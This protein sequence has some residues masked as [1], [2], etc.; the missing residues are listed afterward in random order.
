MTEVGRVTATIDGDLSG[1]ESKLNEAR[2]KSVTAVSGI[3]SDIKSKFGSGISGISEGLSKSFSSGDFL[4]AGKRLGGDLVT[5][6]SGSFG[7]LG[8]AVGEVATALGPVGIAATAG[9]AALVGLGT[10]SIQAASSWETG[11]SQISKTTGIE[12]GTAE[13]A[14]LSSDLLEL[15]A[16]MPVAASE[17][18]SVATSAGSLGVASSEIA[19]FTS[20][21]LQMG[22][23]FDIP[24]EEAAVAI[25]KIKGQLKS[26]PEGAEGADEFAQHFGSAVDSVGNNLNAT[27]ADVLN[28]ATRV[29]GTLSGLGANAYEIAGWGGVLSSVFPSAER[30]AGAFDSAIT[31]LTTNTDAQT[32]ATDLLGISVEEF[33]QQISQDPT[34][35]LLSIGQA[36]ENLPADKVLEVSKAL[37]GSYGMDV[38]TKMIGHTEEWKQAIEETVAAGQKG[39]SIGDSFAAAANTASAQFQ[40]LKGS[41][42]AIFVDIGG[43]ILEAFTPVISGVADGLNDVREIGEN[44][45]EPFTTAISPATT[46]VGL[47]NDSIGGLVDL[48]LDTLVAGAKGI[49]TAFQTGKAFVS[50]FREELTEVV[51]ESETFQTISG[52]VEDFGEAISSVGDTASETFDGMVSWLSD[53]IPTA[54]SGA[55]DAIGTLFDQGMDTLGLGGTADSIKGAFSGLEGFLGDVYENASEKLG[56]GVEDAT[57]EGTEKGMESGS[58]AAEDTISN[59]TKS[60]VSEGFKKASPAIRSALEAGYSD[61]EA[62]AIINNSTSSGKAE[63][64]GLFGRG[65]GVR[66]AEENGIQYEIRYRATKR[67]TEVALYVDG[68]KMASGS[69]YSGQDEAIRD[70]FSQA[71]A[72]LG[73]ATSLTLQG[74]IGEAALVNIIS[75]FDYDLIAENFGQQFSDRL[76][77]EG[78]VIGRAGSE[79]AVAAFSSLLENMRSPMVENLG[80]VLEEIATLAAERPLA[81]SEYDL[82]GDQFKEKLLSQIVDA[83]EFVSTEMG[84]FGEPAAAALSGGIIDGTEASE[85][86]GLKPELEFLQEFFPEQFSDMGG[87]AALELIAALEAGDYEGAAAIISERLTI[88]PT[89]D[90]SLFNTAMTDVAGSVNLADILA[91][92]AE[93]KEK[94]MDVPEFMENTFQP[95]LETQIDFFKTQW[96]SGIAG[97]QKETEDFLSAMIYTSENMPYL[98]TADQVDILYKYSNG[99]ISAKSAIDALSDSADKAADSTKKLETGWDSLQETLQEDEGCECALSDFAK[100]QESQ[101]DLFQGAY[102]GRGGQEYLD[103]K[104]DYL[105]AIAETQEAMKAVGGAVL[106]E[107]YTQQIQDIKMKVSID[108]TDAEA[109]IEKVQEDIEEE[110]KMP[111]KVDDSAAKATI[112]GIDA[113]ASRPVTKLVYVQEVSVGGGGGYGGGYNPYSGVYSGYTGSFTPE[114]GGME[115][116]IYWLPTFASGDV[117][118]PEPTLAIVG[119]RP[120]G[121]W[122]GG[123]DQAVAR[124]GGKPSVNQSITVNYSPVING[125]DLSAAELSELLEEHDEKLMNKIGEKL[126]SSQYW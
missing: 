14:G 29:S 100:W 110:R 44:L 22:T 120:G 83:E 99:L 48:Q 109:S 52:Y 17:I 68:Q 63:Y 92:P 96:H 40:V 56:W 3:E 61:L 111:L 46:A 10:A 115:G 104:L 26:L 57:K 94:V 103:W 112:A 114:T 43:P 23:A 101:T 88:K 82:F 81:A 66:V 33:M 16:T 39:S 117:F 67:D 36:L 30:A 62:L 93:F 49:N 1:L 124:F 89:V 72:P 21:A 85:L 12:K 80:S 60:A 20:V 116:G 47:L 18:Q 8:S 31:N 75:T 58:K 7:P 25:G 118:V 6:I 13:L 123:I 9:A 79:T 4:D 70:L 51:T 53:A 32:A 86:L 95:A 87:E 102:I 2:S 73:E 65:S 71:G 55:A 106:G 113:A 76:E 42:N 59:T 107:D 35:T 98:F 45:W 91:D 34:A 54:V 15:S 105:E 90:M 121:E 108:T 97:A 119:D 41:V 125:S 77:N 5:G 84:K 28:F 64:G 11:M 74:R 19:G 38:F 122:I 24:A 50:A 126:N 27:E 37:G 69:G 78:A